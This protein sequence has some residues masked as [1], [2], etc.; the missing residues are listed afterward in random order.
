MLKYLSIMPTNIMIGGLF[1]L[2]LLADLRAVEEA[3]ICRYENTAI[4]ATTNHLVDNGDGTISDLK[5][6]LMWKKCSEGETWNDNDNSCGGSASPY[7]WQGALQR[8]EAV[9][10][11]IVEGQ[12]NWRVP[13]IK[14][15]AS[16]VELR[17]YNPTINTTVFP[18]MLST[19]FWSSS[20]YASGSAA[21]LVSFYTGSDGSTSKD[22][23]NRYVYVRLVRSGQ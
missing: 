16:I 3:S 6:A 13:N 17:C 7:T 19:F 4:I 2:L 20:S 15:L 21:W 10:E 8:A 18:S 23:V 12:A 22:D 9:N 1:F 5:T 14:E 11:G